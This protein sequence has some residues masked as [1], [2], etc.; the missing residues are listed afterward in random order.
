M[1]W[2][3][4]ILKTLSARIDFHFLR[5]CNGSCNTADPKSRYLV[6]SLHGS[7]RDELKIARHWPWTCRK[8]EKWQRG[9]QPER[10]CSAAAGAPGGRAAPEIAA[11]AAAA[12]LLWSA[13]LAQ[14][15]FFSSLFHPF[16]FSFSLLV[17]SCFLFPLFIFSTLFYFLFFSPLHSFSFFFLFNYILSFFLFFPLFSFPFLIISFP[18]CYLFIYLFIICLFIIYSQGDARWEKHHWLQNLEVPIIC[19]L[20]TRVP[21]MVMKYLPNW[22][23]C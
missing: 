10:G 11:G 23:H 2:A 8:S 5:L 12:L 22:M 17:F 15:A 21:E 4:I 6:I 14:M 16:F 7:R 19:Y 13:S 9:V 3:L 20:K 1:E 18:P